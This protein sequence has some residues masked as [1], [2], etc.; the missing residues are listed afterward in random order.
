MEESQ[1]GRSKKE[2][3][4]MQR[5]KGSFTKQDN[6]GTIVIPADLVKD[7]TFPLRDGCKV[8]IEIGDGKLTVAPLERFEHINIYDDRVT[9]YDNSCHIGNKIGAEIDVY[10]RDQFMI[11]DLCHKTDCEHTQYARTLDKVQQAYKKRGLP[12]PEL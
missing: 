5:K 1:K 12:T 11:C 6:T 2:P 8:M 9:I 3:P 4:K 10:L 7:S